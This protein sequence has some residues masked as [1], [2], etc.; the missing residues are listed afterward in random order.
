MNL[1]LKPWDTLPPPLPPVSAEMRAFIWQHGLERAP[2]WY[3][4]LEAERGDRRAWEE[5]DKRTRPDTRSDQWLLAQAERGN[6]IAWHE[7]D[8]RTRP[9][10]AAGKDPERAAA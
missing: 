8:V 9:A 4:L 2:D 1:P 6:L 3:V 5:I 7:L 10:S